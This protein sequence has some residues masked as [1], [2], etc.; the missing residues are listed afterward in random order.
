MPR[1][2]GHGHGQR[3]DLWTNGGPLFVPHG[4]R[5]RARRYL[6]LATRGAVLGAVLER[7]YTL[8]TRLPFRSDTECHN[9]RSDLGFWVGRA[10]LEPATQGL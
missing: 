7:G 5:W 9:D 3:A 1:R 6:H 10:G 8:A 4:A 2:D